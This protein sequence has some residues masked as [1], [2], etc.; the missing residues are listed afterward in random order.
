MFISEEEMCKLRLRILIGGE[1]IYYVAKEYNMHVSEFEKM[2]FKVRK[3]YPVKK[4]A[5]IENPNKSRCHIRMERTNNILREAEA[6]ASVKSLAKKYGIAEQ[7]VINYI[8]A[9]G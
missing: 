2:L 8:K 3:P 1:N 4:V 7:T 9:R 5:K 6:G